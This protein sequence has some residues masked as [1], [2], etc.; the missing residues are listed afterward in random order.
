M[1]QK[2][3]VETRIVVSEEVWK[4]VKQECLRRGVSANRVAVEEALQL[5][6]AGREKEESIQE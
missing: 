4:R 1:V 5:W 3:L 2:G 6:L